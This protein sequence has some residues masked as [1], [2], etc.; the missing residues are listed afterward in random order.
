MAKSVFTELAA[1]ERLLRRLMKEIN[2]EIETVR[3][4]YNDASQSRDLR[5]S[6]RVN[7]A[8][9]SIETATNELQS[10]EASKTLKNRISKAIQ[11]ADQVMASFMPIDRSS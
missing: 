10:A 6:R 8:L 9:L 1:G 5:L 3:Q 11:N 4:W 7:N 2:C